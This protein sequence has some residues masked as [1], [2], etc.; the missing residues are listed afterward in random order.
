MSIGLKGDASDYARDV[1]QACW[2]MYAII[3]DAIP[4][5]NAV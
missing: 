2:K 1:G 4:S 5:V 3:T